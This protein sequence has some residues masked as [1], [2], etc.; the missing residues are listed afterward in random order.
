MDLITLCFGV[1]LLVFVT[2]LR[3]ESENDEELGSG[4]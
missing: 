2:G 4:A 3:K 1:L